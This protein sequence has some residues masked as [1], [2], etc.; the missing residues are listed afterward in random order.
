MLVQDLYQIT[1]AYFQILS[2]T[3]SFC[4]I[5]HHKTRLKIK[6]QPELVG[7]CNGDAV[8]FL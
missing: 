7:L 3:L 5:Q 1:L 2:N 4:A 6:E 8:C